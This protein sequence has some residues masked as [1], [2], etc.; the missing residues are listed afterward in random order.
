M[1]C[2]RWEVVSKRIRK[3]CDTVN[4]SDETA[5][6]LDGFGETKEAESR[7]RSEFTVGGKSLSEGVHGGVRETSTPCN[8]NSMMIAFVSSMPQCD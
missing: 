7:H 2:C 3:S 5:L 6:L 1:D 4:A 8:Y